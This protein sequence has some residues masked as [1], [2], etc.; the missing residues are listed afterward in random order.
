MR[1][2]IPAPAWLTA[3]LLLLRVPSVPPTHLLPP[4]FAAPPTPRTVQ[5]FRPKWHYFHW[6]TA[7]L[8]VLLTLAMMLLISW[9]FALGV[10]LGVATI[11]AYASCQSA[12][13]TWGDARHG[14]RFRLATAALQG[15]DEKNLAH[16]KNWRPH[17]LVRTAPAAPAPRG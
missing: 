6:S 12:V 1:T 16:A 17:L 8:G 10:L 11:Y 4:P 15:M 5:G 3:C 2:A 7:L 9:Y 14:V 13:H